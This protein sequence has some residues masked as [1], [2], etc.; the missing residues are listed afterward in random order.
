ML[1]KQC[2]SQSLQHKNM[3]LVIPANPQVLVTVGD[4]KVALWVEDGKQQVEVC[5]KQTLELGGNLQPILHISLVG[6]SAISN[7]LLDSQPTILAG[8]RL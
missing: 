2:R 6:T 8:F 3:S 5:V 1:S 4:V 7:E